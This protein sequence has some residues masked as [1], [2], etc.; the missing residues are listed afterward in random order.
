[1]II[2]NFDVTGLFDKNLKI[3]IKDNKLIIVADN[4]SGKTTLLRLMYFFLTK[5][6]SKVIE[7]EFEKI[8]VKING[9]EYIFEKSDFKSN[10]ISQEAYL[11]LAK[12]YSS[13]SNFIIMDFSK[14]DINE[15]KSKDYKIDE[16]E[17]FYDVPK[18]LIFSLIEDLEIKKFDDSIYDWDVSVI[19]L[20]TYRRIE[21]DYFSIFGDMDKRLSSYITNLFPEI[22][23][24]IVVEKSENDNSYSDTEEDLNKIFSEIINS[25]NN[26]K[27]LKNKNSTDKLEMIEFGM[28]DV[29][30]KIKQ[31]FSE[32]DIFRLESI[33]K[34]LT[35][36][37]R[38]LNDQKKLF[39]DQDYCELKILNNENQSQFN[40][41]SLSSGEKQLISVFS[42]LFFDERK[43]FIIIDEPEISLSISWQEMILNDFIENSEGMIVAT[44]SPFI[45]DESLRQYTSGINEFEINE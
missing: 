33:N 3:K 29:N 30:F 11:D 1:M 45:I 7:F 19:Y 5:Q 20:P 16:I 42:H 17:Q 8:K 12:K 10:K 38:Y 35:L 23:E 24:R 27:W 44:H 25:R 18:S 41:N 2:E 26:E 36:I 34:F 15:I 37:N 6:W 43:S 40:L 13:Y 32:K 31:F 39:L 14:Y 4:G 9:K 28:N 21:K 22:R